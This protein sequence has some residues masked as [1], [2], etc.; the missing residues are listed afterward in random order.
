MVCTVVSCP[1]LSQIVFESV[2]TW[3]TKSVYVRTLRMR[4]PLIIRTV[5]TWDAEEE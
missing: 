5:S 4:D 1:K 2:L 3:T